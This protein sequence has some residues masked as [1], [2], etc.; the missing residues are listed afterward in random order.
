MEEIKAYAI[1]RD[2]LDLVGK[3]FNYYQASEW[4]DNKGKKVKNW[5]LKFVSWENNNPKPTTSYQPKE[6]PFKRT[7]NIVE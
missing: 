3:F 6:T 4:K 2:R 7:V 1:E 5:K